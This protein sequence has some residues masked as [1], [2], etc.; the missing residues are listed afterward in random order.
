MLLRVIFGLLLFTYFKGY[1]QPRIVS[2]TLFGSSEPLVITSTRVAGKL[3]N[4]AVPVTLVSSKQIQQ[5]GLLRLQDVLQEQTG[6]AVVNA[7]LASSLNGYPNPFG[8]GI[9]IMG[10]DPAYTLILLD[11]EPLV[12]RN[13]GIV[14]LGRIAIGNIQQLEIVKGPSSCLYGSE[15]MA[16]VINILTQ[17]PQGNRLDVQAYGASRNTSSATLSFSHQQHSTGI[18]AFLHQYSSGGYDLDPATFGKTVD[19]YQ[20]TSANF[21][22]VQELS[23]KSQLSFSFR[24]NQQNQQNRYQI[25]LQATP[26]I[27]AGKATE[28]DA[29][30]FFQWRYLLPGAAKLYIRSFVNTYENNAYVNLEKTGARFD[31]LNFRQQLVKQEMQLQF[32][33]VLFGQMVAGAGFMVDAVTA[34]RYQGN[35]S[36]NTWYAFV[37]QEWK[38]PTYHLTVIAGARID[39]RQDFRAKFSPRLAIAWKP[40]ERWKIAA[41]IGGGFKAPDFRHLYLNYNNPQIGYSLLGAQTLPQELLRLQ[42]AGL[43]QSGAQID[44]YLKPASLLPEYGMGIHGSAGYRA[45]GWQASLGIFYNEINQLIDFFSLPFTRSNGLPVYSYHNVGRIYTG[46][47]EA[48]FQ[49]NISARLKCSLG[50]QYLE[51]KDRD[52]VAAIAAQKIYRRDP[53]TF[54]TEL[55]KQ[56]DY[57]GL[58]NRSK[59]TAQVKIGYEQPATGFYANLRAI[60]RSAAGWMDINGNQIIDDPREMTSGF[61]LLNFTTAKSITKNT[62]IQLG[63]ENILNYTHSVQQPQLPGRT[64]F[65]SLLCSLSNTN[66]KK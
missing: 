40:D 35:P 9:Q 28:Q 27:V 15:A 63:I 13:A 26:E 1:A 7:P 52:V 20:I 53:Q 29:T 54:I 25:Q 32:P 62:S 49:V 10:L 65:V 42:Q 44:P 43:L 50:Y 61:T 33:K 4:V 11:G 21:K 46:G 58:P 5:T 17:K 47:I 60:Y 2:D 23:A 30:A 8:Q 55:V 6:L 22:W 18:Q 48:D 66:N 19:P 36:L 57:L 51:A 38:I 34:T 24:L 16:G 39:E 3:S 64:I 14:N 31:E 45:A 12:G 37:Q 41:S 59:H 56:Q